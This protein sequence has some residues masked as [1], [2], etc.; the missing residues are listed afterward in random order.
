IPMAVAGCAITGPACPVGAV[1]GGVAGKILTIVGI[2]VLVS[3]ISG[4]TN[5]SPEAG[6]TKPELPVG[7]D[8]TIDTKI[9]GQLGERGWTEEEVRDLTTTEPTGTSTDN[10]YGQND[11][12]TVYGSKDKGHVIVNDKTGNVT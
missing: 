3:S 6:D 4:D 8:V 10:T 7:D 2:T 11:S 5:E 12:A 9:E 1:V